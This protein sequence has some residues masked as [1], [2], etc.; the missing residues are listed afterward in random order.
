[1]CRVPAGQFKLC[2][3]AAYLDPNSHLFGRRASV[4]NENPSVQ[5]HNQVITNAACNN[6]GALQFP[7]IVM[8]RKKWLKAPRGGGRTGH[9]E[10]CH[11]P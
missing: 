3:S 4:A 9:D 1:M 2:L 10:T 7:N 6:D 11:P 5:L 8:N